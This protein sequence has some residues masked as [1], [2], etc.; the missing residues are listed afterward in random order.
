MK[1]KKSTQAFTLIELLVVIS[2][3]AILAGI[4]LPVFSQVQ[5]KGKQTQDLSNAKQLG[6]ACKIFATDNDGRYPYQNGQTDPATSPATVAAGL[7]YT[8]NQV[9]ASLIPNYLPSEK[10]FYLAGSAWSPNRPD[11]KTT[12]ATDRCEASSNNYAY[13]Y[14][15]YDTYNPSYPLIFDAPMPA[16]TT[17]STT[18]SAKGG[19]WKAKKAIVVCVDGSGSVQTCTLPAGGTTSTIQGNTGGSA[20]TDILVANAANN[21]LDATANGVLYPQ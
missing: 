20:K 14:G 2:I 11:E 13:M 12:A 6:L 19:V 1:I 4:A 16:A 18:P 3:I 7:Q 21:W 10:V 17:Y 9:F 8:S 5:E 15:M